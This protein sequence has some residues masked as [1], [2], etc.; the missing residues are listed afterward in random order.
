MTLNLTYF[1]SHPIQY[2]SPLL[3][4]LALEDDLSF[5]VVY[6]HDFSTRTYFD[7]GF[8]S[9]V[10]W[11]IPLREGYRS[12]LLTDVSVNEVLRDSDA[13]WF[14]GWQ[15]KL[16]RRILRDAS[17]R[18]KLT[19]MRGE[20]WFGAMPDGYGVRRLARRA[21]HTSIFRYCS[22]FLTIGIKNKEYYLDH[23]VSQARLFDMPYAVDNQ[24]FLQRASNTIIAEVRQSLD[25]TPE[26]KMILYA[27]KLQRR[28]NPHHL[29]EALKTISHNAATPAVLVF[30]G[31]G[32]M[33]RELEV[34]A[35]AS[36][37]IKF[38]GFKN[39][40]EMATYY[41]A[42]DVFVL[43]AER[44]P[45][46]LAINEAMASGTAVVASDQ[47]GAAY[48][49]ITPETGRMT[50]AGNMDALAGAISEILPRS[51]EMGTA[52]QAHVKLWDFEADVRGILSALEALV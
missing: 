11:G 36:P 10:R 5:R 15:S 52:A 9:E 20:N 3:R 34:E 23:G 24:M 19:L 41:A 44:E 12:D 13:V 42:A 43:P 51:K 16:F 17:R 39:Q 21:Y 29:L 30:A 46:G 47:C 22:A 8:Q 28:K 2:Q 6:E 40:T 50:E 31:D 33:R 27:G 4:R 25:V 37:W 49:L 18:R 7:Q 1:L 38:V 26:Q 14:H 35:A 48:D 32:E 45:W